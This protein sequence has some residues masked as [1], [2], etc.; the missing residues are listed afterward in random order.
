MRILLIYHFF[1]P[2]TV[3]SARLFS[4]LAEDWAAAGH[5][6]TVFASNR[7]IRAEGVLPESEEWRGVRICRFSRPAFRQGSNIGRV[8]HS[9]VLQRKWLKA[10]RSQ[11]DAFDTV[12]VGTDPQFGWLMFPTL[13][14]LAPKARLIHWVF[15]L[16]PEALAATGSR[17]MRLAAWLLRPLAKRA[18][19]KVDVMADIGS[20]MRR[21]LRE[22]RHH[23]AEITVTP[24]ALEEPS[25]VAPIHQEMRRK[26]FGDARLC[27]LYSGTVGHAHDLA[28][29]IELARE[30]RRRS[31]PV[32]FCF[33]GYGNRFA[34]Q[35]ALL[36]D[37]DTNVTTA[38]FASEDELA[39]R[40]AA[41]DFHLISLRTGWEGTVVPSKFFGAL[42]MG[43]PVIFSGPE[44]SCLAEWIRQYQIGFL[45]DATLPD[46]LAQAL[47][48][49]ELLRKLQ[50]RAFKT[51]QTTFSRTVQT[52]R[53]LHAAQHLQ[54]AHGR[55]PENPV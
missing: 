22:Y 40:L 21:R 27:L 54:A 1:H 9:L 24:W 16:Y 45:L 33:A 44:G 35:T 46:Y 48:A 41:A 2:D 37:A 49:P 11:R 8:L 3:I 12:V 50:L 31:L 34:E 52:N 38:G 29:F 15:D 6:V 17:L 36:T 25:A 39:A 55:P 47:Q 51:Y 28:P 26:L 23:A 5:Q 7:C 53:L 42:A 20:C 19:A 13:K 18:Y 30:C 14:R 4:D 43:R 32:G 10:F